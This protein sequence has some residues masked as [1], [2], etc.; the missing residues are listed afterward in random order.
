MYLVG[1]RAIGVNYEN[2]DYDYIELDLESG[3]TYEDRTNEHIEYKKHCYHFNKDYMY[4]VFQFEVEDTTDMMFMFNAL[5]YN[6]GANPYNPFDYRDK[7][8]ARL[9]GI[10]YNGLF[11][12]SR[13]GRIRKRFYHI[14]FNLECLEQN[15]LTPTLER[16]KMFHDMKA[17]DADYEQIV[18]EIQNL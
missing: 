5:H 12:K 14:V 15:T 9:K 7:W 8:M 13:T 6:V 11:F 2:S 16:V 1:S 4:K 10:D 18:Q 17:T 3:S